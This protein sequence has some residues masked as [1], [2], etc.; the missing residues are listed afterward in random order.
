MG[1]HGMSSVGHLL[2][3]ISIFFFFFMLLDSAI[4]KKYALSFLC[5]IPRFYK[6]IN[7]YFYKISFYQLLNKHNIL[8]IVKRQHLYLIY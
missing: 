2:T 8:P 3:L 6:R 4:E 5:G 7:Y 1:W